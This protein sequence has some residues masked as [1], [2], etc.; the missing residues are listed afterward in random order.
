MSARGEAKARRARL[1]ALAGATTWRHTDECSVGFPSTPRQRGAPLHVAL[2]LPAAALPHASRGPGTGHP[3]P[4][5]DLHPADAARPRAAGNAGDDAAD[6]PQ[7]R[8]VA[9]LRGDVP[10]R[11]LDGSDAVA[12]VPQPGRRRAR[13]ARRGRVV[14]RRGAAVH[15]GAR[16]RRDAAARDHRRRARQRAGDGRRDS[17]RRAAGHAR[18][19]GTAS[20]PRHARPRHAVVRFSAGPVARLGLRA[21]SALRRRVPGTGDR[22]A[23]AAAG[24]R[25]PRC[26]GDVPRRRGGPRGIAWLSA[27]RPAAARRVEGGRTRRRLVHETVRG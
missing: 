26:A 14:R 18:G 9:G 5:P 24:P 15:A 3:A 2:A 10:A 22:G 16:R 7:L 4:Q 12:H 1:R 23:A 8:A 27:G 21:F 19:V 17:R 25:R 11:G 20:R 13:A 6:L